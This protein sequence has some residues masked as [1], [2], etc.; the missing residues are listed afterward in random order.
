[1]SN[2]GGPF[3]CLDA[4]R[5]IGMLIVMTNH[6]AFASGFR[7]RNDAIGPFIA[8]F[9]I[10]IPIFFMVSGF[11]LFRPIV[12]SMLEGRSPPNTRGYLRNRG[13]RILPAYWVAMA[14][15]FIWWGL[16]ELDGV[17]PVGVILFYGAMLQTFVASI[18]FQNYPAFDQAWS[19]GTEVTFYLLLPVAALGLRRWL[20]GSTPLRMI[21]N[22]LWFCFA[23]WC[24]AQVW[25]SGLVLLQPSW[26]GS[27]T[28]WLPAN[29]DFFGIGMAMAVTSAAHQS[30]HG[31]PRW[32]E[33]LGERPWASW[34]IA[35]AL[36]LVVVNPF[37][38]DLFG[39][40]ELHADPLDFS[41]EYVAKLFMYGIVAA[42]FLLPAMFGP[43]REG[44]IRAFLSSRPMVG[45]GVVSLGFYLWHKAWLLQA[46]EWT[47]AT[48]FNGSFSKLLAITGAGGL[49]CGIISYWAVERPAIGLKRR[50]NAPKVRQPVDDAAVRQP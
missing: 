46:E 20:T 36:W 4:Y 34:L 30:G 49:A 35:G 2:R 48:P 39:L 40:F 38:F 25:R 44:L 19:I 1:V 22:L 47:G 45:L 14:G 15:V 21:R 16:P 32:I 8:R 5:G 10:A 7:F 11:L 26:I 3:P 13:L 24:V 23:L 12:R 42:F 31:L 37:A 41:R 43:Q 29:I 50:S 28:F 27:A 33:A 6:V 9:D 18:V 17:S